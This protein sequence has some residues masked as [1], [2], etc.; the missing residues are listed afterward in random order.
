MDLMNLPI[1]EV[2]TQGLGAL[3]FTMSGILSGLIFGCVGMWMFREGKRRTDFKIVCISVVLMFYPYFTRGPIEDWG[4]G[5]LLCG[6]A[7]YLW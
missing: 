7:Y 4:A 5:F 6:L 1:D 2:A 3:N